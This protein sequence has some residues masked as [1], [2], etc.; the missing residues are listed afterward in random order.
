MRKWH[1][2]ICTLLTSLAGRQALGEVMASLTGFVLLA[3][4]FLFLG[5]LQNSFWHTSWELPKCDSYPIAVKKITHLSPMPWL[6][7]EI[8]TKIGFVFHYVYY[9]DQD[10][11]PSTH[12][13]S[14]QRTG[15]LPKMGA[16]E[17]KVIAAI[18]T[19][20]QAYECWERHLIIARES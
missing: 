7:G 11:P 9:P 4:I 1:I 8:P 3:R 2:C 6:A 12:T 20:R 17:K 16:G 10:I 13:K 14:L 19:L 15:L 5:R 18:V